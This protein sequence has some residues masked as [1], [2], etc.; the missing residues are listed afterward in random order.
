MMPGMDGVEAM[1]EGRARGHGAPDGTVY[2]ILTALAGVLYYHGPDELDPG[3]AAD[4]RA[5][6]D[7]TARRRVVV[8]QVASLTD[9]S[10]L[11]WY[12]RLVPGTP[13]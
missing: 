7:D 13:L 2:V 8:D 3:F 6:A 9:Q 10:A 4:W 12:E 5:A 1:E 11:L